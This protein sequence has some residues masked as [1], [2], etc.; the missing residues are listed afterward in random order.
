MKARPVQHLRRRLVFAFTAFALLIATVFG[1]YSLVFM[2]AVEDSLFN[3]QLAREA[4]AQLAQHARDG[5]WRTPADAAVQLHASPSTFP[6]DLRRVF[7]DEPWRSEFTGDEGRHYH[8]RQ[9]TPAASTP[10]AWLVSEVSSQLVVR[11]IRDNVVMLLAGTA[12]VMVLLAIV[13]GMWLAHRVTRRLYALVEEVEILQPMAGHG[14]ELAARFDGDEIGVLARALDGLSARVAAF[15][16]REHAFTRD[17]SHELRT[18]LTVIS[19]AAGQLLGEPGLSE[20]GRQHVQHVRLS[21]L[22][23]QQAVAALLALAR[24]EPAG[25]RAEPVRLVPLLE[26]VIVEQSPLLASRPVQVQLVVPDDATL[27][28]PEA[29]LHVVLANLIGNAFA[30]TAH[31]QVLIALDAGHLLVHNTTDTTPSLGNW[32]EPRPFDKRAGS[33]GSGLGLEIMRRLCSHHGLHLDIRV[34]R[35]GVSARLRGQ[36]SGP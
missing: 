13:L 36:A 10:P 23:L 3:A 22:Q 33:R 16:A 34:E 6:A 9:L 31:G 30:H 19:G 29:A 11:P 12:L 14:T 8:L 7:A 32:P 5:R 4:Q 15:V 20:R 28:A 27:R 26:R 18:P 25:H 17:A 2:Y 24:E 21:A 1:L 35:D